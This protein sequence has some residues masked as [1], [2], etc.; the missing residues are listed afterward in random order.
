MAIPTSRTSEKAFIT[1]DETL[2]TGCYG[3][4]EVCKTATTAMYAAE[5]RGMGACM[6][7]AVHPLIL[8]GKQAR[9][10]RMKYGIRYTSREGVFVIFGYPAVTYSKGISRTF[11]SVNR[12]NG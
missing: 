12:W 4:V 3:C 10:F 9:K 2:C 5:A 7:G 6:L 11:A 8:N 1:I